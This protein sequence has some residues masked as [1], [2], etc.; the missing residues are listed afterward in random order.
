MDKKRA[1]GLHKEMGGHVGPEMK[2][3]RAK[4]LLRQAELYLKTS[5]S[6]GDKKAI[7][8]AQAMVSRFKKDIAD[9]EKVS[10]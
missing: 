4:D 7:A 5:K 1:R 10:K 9:L 2:L 6:L 3:A 8:D